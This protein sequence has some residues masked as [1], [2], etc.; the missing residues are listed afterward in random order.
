MIFQNEANKNPLKLTQ[1]SI[2][3]IKNVTQGATFK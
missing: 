2:K 3:D 1:K